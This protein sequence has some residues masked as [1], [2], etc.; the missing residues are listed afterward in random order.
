MVMA[1]TA[2]ISLV[3]MIS[4]LAL[5]PKNTLLLLASSISWIIFA[6]LAYSYT[7]DNAAINVG[8]LLFGGA[9][10]IISAVSALGVIMS[11]RPAKMSSEGE[12][13][14][15][16]REVLKITKKRRQ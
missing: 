8:L 12:Q 13:R 7:F 15:Y 6:F 11:K 4:G 9:M 3:L 14:A 2:F 1:T 5:K 10:A 16:K